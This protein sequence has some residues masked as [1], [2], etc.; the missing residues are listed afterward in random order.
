MQMPD[1]SHRKLAGVG[2]SG[3]YM[4]TGRLGRRDRPEQMELTGA[5][6]FSS[7]RGCRSTSQAHSSPRDKGPMILGRRRD[8]RKK[9]YTKSKTENKEEKNNPQLLAPLQ[10][11]T[12]SPHYKKEHRPRPSDV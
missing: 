6:Q 12:L 10:I 11:H 1:S 3:E 7:Q 9:K 4:V 2:R 5:N 8:W